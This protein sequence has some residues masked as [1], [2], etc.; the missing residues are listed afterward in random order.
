VFHES[1]LQLIFLVDFQVIHLA[2]RQTL[3]FVGQFF[4]L[5]ENLT[6]GAG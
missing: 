4:G 3:A 2:V 5:K 1:F 6:F